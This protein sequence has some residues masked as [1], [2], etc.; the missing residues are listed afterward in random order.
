MSVTFRVRCGVCCVSYY[1][2][3]LQG[4]KDLQSS[5]CCTI[6]S[7]HPILQKAMKNIPDEIMVLRWLPSAWGC[8]HQR[9][10]L[11]WLSIV[12]EKYYGCGN[13]IPFGLSGLTVLDLGSGSGRDCYLAS[14]LVGA[15]G[16]VIGVDMTDQQLAVAR[17]HVEPFTK[18]MGSVSQSIALQ[19]KERKKNKRDRA[20]A[21]ACVRACVCKQVP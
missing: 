10:T 6:S 21:C 15:S 20:C 5:T 9:L 13:T 3:Q 11:L 2:R 14:Q 17:K 1:G 16:Q 18:L 7:P 12:Q 8:A 19:E 4:T